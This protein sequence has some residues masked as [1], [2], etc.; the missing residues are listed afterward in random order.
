[1]GLLR[2][3]IVSIFLTQLG[4][5]MQFEL[6][7]LPSLTK[8]LSLDVDESNR[9]VNSTNFRNYPVKGRCGVFAEPVSIRMGSVTQEVSCSSEGTFTGHLDLEGSL[10][11]IQ[12]LEV[13]QA[14]SSD[15]ENNKEII[16]ILIDLTPP[17][18]TFRIPTH[19]ENY[20]LSPLRSAFVLEGTCSDPMNLVR[21]TSSLNQLYQVV[22]SNT[23]KWSLKLNL[24]QETAASIDY[25]AQHFD[26]AGNI[27]EE[28]SV[29]IRYPQ[30][31]K[32]SPKV[33]STGFSS[34]RAVAPY[35]NSGRMLIA[36]PLRND[37]LVDLGIVN[38]DGTGLMRISPISGQWG[39]DQNI[40]LTAVPK[41]NRAIYGRFSI[42]RVQLKELRTVKIDG[43]DDRLLVGPN[44][45]NPVGGVTRYLITPDEEFVIAMGDLES[46]DNEFNIYSVRIRDGKII[47]LNGDLVLGGD[48]RDF[49][50]S[51][52]GK[53]V[54]FRVDKDTDEAID[55]WAVGVDGS[56]LRKLNQSMVVG[57]LVS[58]YEIS[59]DSSWVVFK[60]NKSHASYGMSVV[61]LV[62]GEELVLNGT[63]T[64]GFPELGIFSPNSKALIY[65]TDREIAGC[66]SLYV[67]NIEL[68]TEIRASNVCTNANTDVGTYVWSPDSQTIAFSQAKVTGRYDL[69]LVQADGSGM[70]ALAEA[71]VLRNGLRQGFKVR[72]ILFTPD[73]KSVVFEA[74]LSGVSPAIAN[75]MKYSLHTVNV[76]QPLVVTNLTPG[77][78]NTH[79]MDYPIL[80]ISPD[81][82]RVAFVADL[83]VDAKYEF[84]FA[85]LD[86]T[87][88]QKR[89]PQI[90]NVD[91]DV[92]TTT[93][94][95]FFD[96]D[97]S[98]ATLL[99]D[100][101]IDG[102]YG[103]YSVSLKRLDNSFRKIPTPLVLS[104]DFFTY[105][106]SGDRNK[107]LIRGNPEVDA[108]MHLYIADAD[109]SN[110]KRVTDPYPNGGGKFVSAVISE[111]G[112]HVLYLADQVTAGVSELF[113]RDI[114]LDQV[115][116]LNGSFQHG[117]GTVQGFK[118]NE[119]TQT[120]V[121]L[122]NTET[123]KD[124]YFYAV[125]I[126]G[127]GRIQLSP[128]TAHL[129]NILSWDLSSD[130]SYIV[131]RADLNRDEK[132]EIIKINTDGSGSPT[133]L[134]QAIADTIDMSGFK[135]SPDSQWVCYWGD[136]T[137]AKHL[138]SYV[139]NA[140][141]PAGKNYL[142]KV[143]TDAARTSTNCSFSDDSEYV[144]VV[145]DWVTDG[146]SRLVSYRISDQTLYD[147]NPSLYSASH[148]SFY[149]FIQE[150]VNKRWIV[151]SETGPDVYEIFSMNLDGTDLRRISKSPYPGGSVN[152][153]N[154][155]AVKILED[156]NRTIVYTGLIDTLGKWDLYSVKWD[157]SESRKLIE[158]NSYADIYDIYTFPQS[159]KLYFRADQTK[160][161]ILS[162]YSVKADGTQ[163]KNHS[164]GLVGATGVWNSIQ[165]THSHIFFNSDAY[166]SQILEIFVDPI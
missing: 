6:T 114:A 116:R 67:Y 24:S 91:G 16:K 81:G 54:V 22:C 119:S 144:L 129:T 109:G 14:S 141:D 134:N 78:T 102:V 128:P 35:G 135:I 44:T 71:T 97:K 89:G 41:Q 34:V 133:V 9:S 120:V 112:S 145:G 110:L 76:E 28:A 10:E 132:Y 74:D 131:M 66:Y 73:S 65:R 52:D 29:T 79:V 105:A 55:L 166:N 46:R 15:P 60:E 104:G 72:S 27:S 70:T 150:G 75:D 62:D 122:A 32:V 111:N 156:A 40:Q 123:D 30:W 11:G 37:D 95:H 94:M 63:M 159:E 86:G 101:T 39:L 13:F 146:R 163:L 126:D 138:A 117:R 93:L 165:R 149:S 45:A 20:A 7:H 68:K 1:M 162:L 106:V 164:P 157:G 88:F 115:T 125:K 139:A 148:S 57:K 121:Y 152:G 12:E 107:I 85:T 56:R 113:V 26:Q 50:I 99:I 124:F 154:G 42:G 147:L 5:S 87:I 69:F 100:D 151:Q 137:S 31:N 142:I 51:P 19:A 80:E 18:L 143:A 160:D 153:N 58:D 17:D 84:Y 103:N 140:L 83:D 161:G 36:A 43:T 98:T 25:Y 158:L 4:C 136:R 127:T 90:S 64:N 48:V 108:E 61:S 59:S 49:K 2:Y 21:V 47:R 96:W 33:T 155:A 92:Q 118:Y 77:L 53:T 130:G 82:Q 8:K 3:V 23:Q 38:S